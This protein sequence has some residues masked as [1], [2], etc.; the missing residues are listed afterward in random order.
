M[1]V[2]D[3]I[4]WSTVLIL[5]ATGVYVLSVK[6]QWKTFGKVLGVLTLAI[7]VIGGGVW[8][9]VRWDSRP[10]VVEEYRDIKLGMSRVEATLIKGAPYSGLGG[11][12]SEVEEGESEDRTL[13]SLSLYFDY[14]DNGDNYVVAVL[15]GTSEATLEVGRVCRVGGYADL[16]G[17]GPY[18]SEEQVIEKLGTPSSVSINSDGLS[19]WVNY[20]QW[21]VA[22]NIRA[23]NVG[24]RCMT[25][26]DMSYSDEY[27]PNPQE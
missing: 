17:F 5:L 10:Y 25:D 27:N 24:A 20:D 19:K 6:R 2:G 18:S 16:L 3:G 1:T 8:G 9:Y 26:F 11:E 7:A 23:G 22:Y 12:I 15:W 13:Y 4:F 14:F 21:N